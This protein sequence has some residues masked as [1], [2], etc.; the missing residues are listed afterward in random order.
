MKMCKVSLQLLGGFVGM[1]F[2]TCPLVYFLLP[3]ETRTLNEPFIIIT[4]GIAWLII[5]I[6]C[7]YKLM[8]RP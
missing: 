6:Y 5:S 1:A 4:N 3:I 2:A 8:R 7:F